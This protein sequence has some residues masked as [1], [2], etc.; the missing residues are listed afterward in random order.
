MPRA[1]SKASAVWHGDL[2][3]GS[4]SISLKS[5]VIQNQPVSWSARTER[6]DNTSQTSP[7]EL[8]AAA[9][10]SCYCMGLSNGLGGNG[11]PADELRVNATAIFDVGG[12][13][14]KVASIHLD[15]EGKVPGLSSEDFDRFAQDAKTGCPV[16]AALKGNVDLSVDAKLVS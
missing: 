16:G 15:L 13:G 5:G 1:E 7:E 10:A 2:M 8:I 11:T 9:Y 4:G 3:H 6:G 12:G 14:V